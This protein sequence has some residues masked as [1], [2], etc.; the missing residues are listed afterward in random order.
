MFDRRAEALRRYQPRF[1]A[2][3]RPDIARYLS[4]GFR[5]VVA[6]LYW[7]GAVNYFGDQRNSRVAYGE[8]SNYLELILALDP[9]FEYA[10]LFGGMALPWNKGKGWVNIDEAISILERGA[11]RFPNDW[12]L[13]F[14]LAF[15]YSEYRQRY[16][17]AGNQLAA[18][19]VLAGA[20][21]YLGRLAARMYAATGDYDGALSIVEQLAGSIDDPRIRDGMLRRSE[22]IRTV[23][24]LKKLEELVQRFSRER[25]R[26]PASLEELVSSGMVKALPEE[27]L[28]GVFVY[29]S[30]SGE[31]ESS[32]LHDRLE[33]FRQDE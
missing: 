13:R 31:V 33:I 1:V 17:D 25:G 21:E 15:T 6:D 27:G 5:A 28:G 30:A 14:Q 24:K 26:L 29:D 18:A 9:D 10:Y 20:P 3:P 2:L 11:K 12:R 7:I 16:K 19:A 22:E 32:V 8:L 23:K 4:L